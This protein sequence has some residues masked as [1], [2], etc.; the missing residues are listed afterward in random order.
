MSHL[1]PIEL[2]LALLLAVMAMALLSARLKVP[3]P[4]LLVLGGLGVSFIPRLPRV[5]L[6]PDLVFLVFLPPLLYYAGLMTTW[7]D[8]RANLRPIALLA[9][10]LV[11][12]TTV[13]IAFVANALIPGLPLAAAFVLGAIVSPPDA[14]AATAITERLRVP[15]RITTILDGE[16]LVNDATALVAYRFAIAAVV[17]GQFSLPAALGKFVVAATLGILIGLVAAAVIVWVSQRIHE[18]NVEGAISLLTPYLAYLPAEWAG[19]SGVLGAVAAGIYVSRKLPTFASPNARLRAFAVWET[20]VFLLNGIIFILI[21]LQLPVVMERLAHIPRGR[22]ALYAL[23]VCATAILTRIIW[24]FVATYVRRTV[25]AKLRQHDPVL[26]WRYVT[27]IG[28]SGMRGIVSLAAA[29]ALPLTTATDEPF[30]GRDLIIFL[31]FTVI[32]ATLVFQGLTLPPLIR[33]L[34]LTDDGLQ[35]REERDA[36]VQAAH[37][38]LSRL[39]VLSLDP[40]ADPRVLDRL[41][42]IYEERLQR[43]G[44]HTHHDH[45]LEHCSPQEVAPT[46]HREALIAERRMITFLRDQNDIS[47]TVLRRLLHEI[48]LEE[49][50]LSA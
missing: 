38:A 16:S 30:P 28:W 7:R 23:A 33:L 46:V 36:R 25:S 1:H 8:F 41:R 21:G 27:I 2:V 19:A 40:T 4:I 14:V 42:L 31:S 48:D 13:A 6:Q 3:Y 26:P 20:I 32:L 43:L 47:D 10:G 50:R 18:P 35:E 44:D 37:A 45:A 11:L 17:T 24:I 49:A 29:L 5:H 34:K 9:V 39:H 15:R 22:L 12:F